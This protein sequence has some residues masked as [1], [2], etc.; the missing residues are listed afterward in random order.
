ME[1]L[2]I[3]DIQGRPK[4]ITRAN[5]ATH[6]E[7]ANGFSEFFITDTRT[8]FALRTYGSMVANYGEPQSLP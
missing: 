5:T 3:S 6:E 1:E 2:V 7:T 8:R 4:A